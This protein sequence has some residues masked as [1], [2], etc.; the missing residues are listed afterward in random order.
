VS[1]PGRVLLF[2]VGARLFA[3]DVRDVVRIASGADGAAERIAE[4][5]L[6]RA[7]GA[8]RGL[9]V[10]I[11]AA[12]R[13]LLVDLVLGVHALGPGDLHALPPLAEACLATGA[14]RGLVVLEGAP[15]PLVDLPTLVREGGLAAVPARGGEVHA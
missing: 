4:T 1:A 6:G 5:P 15:T 13:V 2:H 3:A 14:V 7:Q 11:G 12:E 9:V 8:A 10:R